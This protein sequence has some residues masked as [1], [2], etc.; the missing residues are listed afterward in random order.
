M[1]CVVV[2]VAIGVAVQKYQ[3]QQER[4]EGVQHRIDRTIIQK[5]D[6]H[7]QNVAQQ[8]EHRHHEVVEKLALERNE[9][10]LKKEEVAKK[11]ADK[12]KQLEQMGAGRRE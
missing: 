8:E 12:L 2:G 5:R 9:L 7:F 6:D 3:Q 10:D 1:G 4:D 11:L